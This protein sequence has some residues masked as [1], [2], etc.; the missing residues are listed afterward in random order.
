MYLQESGDCLEVAKFF[1]DQG[2]T[3]F[4]I[5]MANAHTPGGGFM[6]GAGVSC[7]LSL[8]SCATRVNPVSLIYFLS[9]HKRRVCIVGRVC[10]SASRIPKK[11]KEGKED[12]TTI[13]SLLYGPF[14]IHRSRQLKLYKMSQT[15]CYSVF[16]IIA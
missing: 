3:T 16:P 8:L 10:S 5:N 11:F 9:R 7:Y 6:H 4:C 1:Q 12:R 2:N 14:A 15:G 13:L